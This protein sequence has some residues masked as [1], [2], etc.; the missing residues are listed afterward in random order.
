MT[1]FTDA[2]DP[3]RRIIR[4][5][6]TRGEREN[7]FREANRHSQ[8]VRWLK[9]VLPG[10]AILA[11]IVFFVAMRLVADD[12]EIAVSL[13]GINVEEKNLVMK[14]PHISGFQKTRQSYEITAVR[15]IQDLDNPKKVK[16]E[17][18][19][20]TFGMGGTQ[21]AIVDAVTGVYDGAIMVLTGG[22]DAKTNDGYTA[23]LDSASI[24]IASGDLSS[25]VPVEIH[26][27]DGSINAH[28]MKVTEHGKRVLFSNGVIV[29]YLPPD[30]PDDQAPAN[31]GAP[32][33]ASTTAPDKSSAAPSAEPEADALK[34]TVPAGG[35]S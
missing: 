9:F 23:K 2:P 4:F 28:A 20:A 27:D 35:S 21:T 31:P 13:A 6:P 17:T 29:H 12:S 11:V 10:L 34:G 25:S 30:E 1:D 3:A 32:G 16:L 15:A 7:D 33:A 18:I 19:H 8:R 24:D 5:D 14:T 26:S 22:I